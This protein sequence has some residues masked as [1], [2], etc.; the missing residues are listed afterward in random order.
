MSKDQLTKLFKY[1][2]KRFNEM[3]QKFE[4]ASRNR[5][6]IRGPQR[7]LSTQVRDSHNDMTLSSHQLDKLS[8]A[9]L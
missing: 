6:D 7:E 2:E 8:D 5:A 4:E 3:N 9:I 1:V